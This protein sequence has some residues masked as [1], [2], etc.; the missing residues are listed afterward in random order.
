MIA[1]LAVVA[2]SLIVALLV[3][4]TRNSSSESASSS[5]QS[6]VPV[7]TPIA[8]YRSDQLARLRAA[9]SQGCPN[10]R[11]STGVTRAT[12]LADVGVA[13]RKKC[14]YCGCDFASLSA[15]SEEPEAGQS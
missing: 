9:L 8:L 6:D 1:L 14:F 15:E 5:C 3:V 10:C 4:V 7:Q 2:L 13:A 12:S 11:A